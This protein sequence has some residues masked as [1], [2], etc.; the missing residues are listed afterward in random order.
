MIATVL[1]LPIAVDGGVNEDSI[2]P[3]Y[4]AG[5]DV[6][7][8]GTGLYRHQGDLGPVV[9]ELRVAARRG[10]EVRPPAGTDA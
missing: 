3:A 5:G 8:V 4:A 2:G 9:D 7:V 10:I 1:D 6:L